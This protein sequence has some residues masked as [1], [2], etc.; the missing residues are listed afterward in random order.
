MI[1]HMMSWSSGW[2]RRSCRRRSAQHRTGARVGVD[3][4]GGLLW[5]ASTTRS[6]PD[7]LAASIRCRTQPRRPCGRGRQGHYDAPRMGAITPPQWVVA[8]F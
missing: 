3:R 7:L 4:I 5:R 8:S 2:L 6:G 1:H